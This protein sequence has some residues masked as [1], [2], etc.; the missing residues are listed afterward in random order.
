MKA[1]GP[2][3]SLLAPGTPRPVE[4]KQ[5]MEAGSPGCRC[6]GCRAGPRGLSLEA[7]NLGFFCRQ[8]SVCPSPQARAVRGAKHRAPRAQL[9]LS[10]GDI[11][12][13]QC[14]SH[15]KLISL[16]IMFFKSFLNK[17]EIQCLFPGVW[18]QRPGPKCALKKLRG[19][20]GCT[21][22]FC[23]CLMHLSANQ[24]SDVLPPGP[25][26]VWEGHCLHASLETGHTGP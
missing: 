7:S 9:P 8:S 2:A 15:F 20:K 23:S 16:C 26:G 18:E 4:N 21:G 5:E 13:F 10:L 25:S 17:T 19:R 14:R 22:V 12:A 24:Q 3:G 1:L 11:T 6:K